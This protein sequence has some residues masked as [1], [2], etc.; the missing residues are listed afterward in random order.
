MGKGPAQTTVSLTL[1]VLVSWTAAAA[2]GFRVASYNLNNYLLTQSGTRRAKSL[3][4]KAAIRQTLRALQADVLALQEVGGVAAL[5]ELRAVLQ[6]DGLVY[7]HWEHITAQ[8]TNIQVAVLS[9]FPII[10]R[11]PHTNDSYLLYGRRFRVGRGFAEVQIQVNSNYCFTLITAHLKS[12]L[13]VPEGDQAELREQEATLLRAKVDAML[14]RNPDANLVLLG[15]LN[16]TQDTPAIR[17][18]TRNALVDTR[19]TE[20]NSTVTWTYHYAKEDTY[21]RVDYILLSPGMAR[22]WDRAQTYVLSLT[23]WHVA[24]D[25]RPLVATF[26]AENR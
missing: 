13:P 14:K 15:D 2:E 11:Q 24:S 23:N 16:D 20:Q 4:G 12:K 22:E 1:L 3:E 19:P 18:M 7:P 25:H 6:S 17:T 26:Y 9:R 5:E 21:S 10:A 8:D